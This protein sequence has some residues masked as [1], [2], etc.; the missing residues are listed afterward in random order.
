[1]DTLHVWVLKIFVRRGG[2]VKGP[3]LELRKRLAKEM[4][5]IDCSEFRTSKLCLDCGRIAKFPKKG[6]MYGVTYCSGSER[7]HHRMANRD[8]VAAF[9]IGAR[10]LA[11]KRGTDLGPWKRGSAHLNDLQSS[12]VLSDVLTSY[13][14]QME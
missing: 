7:D 14:R 3:V 4:V 8:V 5:V 2:G 1:M 6:K 11:T 13:Q 10:Y 12:T 9:K